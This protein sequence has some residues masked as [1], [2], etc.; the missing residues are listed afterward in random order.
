M[1]I[2]KTLKYH[3]RPEAVS[4][5]QQFQQK[6]ALLYRK[7]A[8]VE[9]IFLD[10][11]E[12]HLCKKEI[13]RIHD[14]KHEKVLDKINNNP[15]ILEYYKVFLSTILDSSKG[16]IEEEEYIENNWTNFGKPHHIE[17]Y[18]SNLEK[19]KEFWSWFLDILGYKT[20]QSWSDGL[21]LKL[22]ETY[23]VFVQADMSLGEF[24][25][26]RRNPGLNHMAF[27]AINREQVDKVTN[28]LK[29]RK[30]RILYEDRHPYAGGSNYYAVFFEDPEKIK[31]E[32]VAPN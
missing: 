30:M 27:H 23:F 28:K 12:N 9:F 6:V 31:I 13:I 4:T 17:I 11:K 21:S 1:S 15:K 16:P 25:Y 32:L 26:N 5:Y 24:N 7:Y 2:T 22:G 29:E 10:S 18:C 20:Y 19:S 8:E 14:E 3:I